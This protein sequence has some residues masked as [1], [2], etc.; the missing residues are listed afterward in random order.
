M[1]IS[2]NCSK[3]GQ[4]MVIDEDAAGVTIDCPNCGE[5]SHVPSQSAV[6]ADEPEPF[7]VST[8]P[9]L[10]PEP[11]AQILPPNSVTTRTEV[12]VTGIQMPFWSVVAFMIKWAVASIPAAIVLI[13]IFFL[14]WFLFGLLGMGLMMHGL[15]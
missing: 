5:P 7:A 3:C 6:V 10:S 4:S 9:P 12:V 2:F 14:L 15:H 8:S 1:D 11:P 13:T